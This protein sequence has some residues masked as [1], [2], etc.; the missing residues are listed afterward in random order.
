MDSRPGPLKRHPAPHPIA[1]A[2]QKEDFLAKAQG[3]EKL[4]KCE[5][6]VLRNWNL[7]CFASFA[8]L[9]EIS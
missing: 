5:S 6:Q 1:C 2:K 9:R 4:A 7:L 8:P 3:P